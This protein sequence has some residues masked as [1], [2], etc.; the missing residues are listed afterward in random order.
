MLL[1]LLGYTFVC[2]CAFVHT[3]VQAKAFLTGL[4]SSYSNVAVIRNT[5]CFYLFLFAINSADVVNHKVEC[6]C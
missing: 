6:F 5:C 2:V 1:L 3:C 4:R